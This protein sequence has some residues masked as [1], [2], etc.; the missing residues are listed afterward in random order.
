VSHDVEVMAAKLGF[1]AAF[2]IGVR[3]QG[4]LAHARVPI[5]SNNAAWKFR[6]QTSGYWSALRFS[7]IG[8]PVRA[9]AKVVAANWR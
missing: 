2:T 4:P 3:D 7:R 5:R 9:V 1:L 6:I 8:H